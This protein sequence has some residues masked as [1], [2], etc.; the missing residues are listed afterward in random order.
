MTIEKNLGETIEY[1]TPDKGFDIAPY[2]AAGKKQGI[3]HV[4]RYQ[5]ASLIVR[6][7]KPRRIID[8]ACGAG[9]G[10]AMLAEASPS[11]SVVGV[12]YDS[13]AIEFAT[14]QYNRENLTYRNGS[15]VTWTDGTIPLGEFDM[16]T[17]FDTLEHILHREIAMES[18]SRNLSDDGIMLFSTPCRKENI[19]NPGWEHHKIEYSA[20]DLYSFLS[21]YFQRVM[22]PQDPLFPHYRYWKEIINKDTPLY[23]NWMNP[24]VCVGPIRS[25]TFVT[26]R[27]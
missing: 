20:R 23:Y 6:D 24:L 15:I 27:I 17:S 3:H 4:G 7:I 16:I 22:Q 19:L 8:I 9:Y 25:K 10:S 2:I 1:F 5:W 26:Y 21:R 14:K 11:S 12:D 13:R 18:I